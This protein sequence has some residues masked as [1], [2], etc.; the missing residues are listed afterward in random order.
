MNEGRSYWN[1]G[2]GKSYHIY[3]LLLKRVEYMVQNLFKNSWGACVTGKLDKFSFSG[4]NEVFAL[5]ALHGNRP[6]DMLRPMFSACQLPYCSI[7]FK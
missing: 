4:Q 3:F 5:A 1:E 6:P 2:R 7:L